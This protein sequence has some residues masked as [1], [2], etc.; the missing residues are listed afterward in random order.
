MTFG[1]ARRENRPFCSTVILRYNVASTIP[2][3]VYSLPA[4]NI[5]RIK[6]VLTF[7]IVY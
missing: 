7:S 2:P 4:A 3:L 5:D 6:N 1:C